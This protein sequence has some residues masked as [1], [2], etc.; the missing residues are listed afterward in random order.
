MTTGNF[1]YYDTILLPASNPSGYPKIISTRD[2]DFT[3]HNSFATID[4]LA[5]FL[6][7][8]QYDV[9]RKF[10]DVEAHPRVKVLRFNRAI[11]GN[12]FYVERDGRCINCWSIEYGCPLNDSVDTRI[13]IGVEQDGSW[14]LVNLYSSLVIPPWGCGVKFMQDVCQA[15]AAGIM[16]GR[17]KEERIF[18]TYIIGRSWLS[19]TLRRIP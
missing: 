14:G 1:R 13:M 11:G 12:D 3:G 6:Y 10:M 4:A 19:A 17:K 2:K 9:L 5:T 15:F 8:L 18:V 16:N 7:S